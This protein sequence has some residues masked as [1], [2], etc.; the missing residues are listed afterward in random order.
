MTSADKFL[1]HASDLHYRNLHIYVFK[2][3]PPA[4]FCG[5]EQNS[6][7]P[8]GQYTQLCLIAGPCIKHETSEPLQ[9]TPKNHPRATS[10][11]LVH[12]DLQ[13]QKHIPMSGDFTKIG[14]D[15]VCCG[16]FLFF[17]VEFHTL[18]AQWSQEP[19]PNICPWQIL[20]DAACAATQAG[21]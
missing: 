15:N 2:S 13:R 12:F 14:E 20:F 10:Q 21:A 17:L 6:M 3:Q 11:K 4:L 18:Q 8:T 16:T 1:K 9:H 19:I 7:R 5:Y